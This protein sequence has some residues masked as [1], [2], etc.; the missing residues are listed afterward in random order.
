M[1]RLLPA[2]LASALIIFCQLVLPQH[3]KAEDGKM[4]VAPNNSFESDLAGI[5]T[6]VC[7]FGGWFPIGVV[8]DDGASEIE[9]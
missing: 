9:I 1:N 5:N 2:G 6:N 4:N 8:T 3:V 7:V